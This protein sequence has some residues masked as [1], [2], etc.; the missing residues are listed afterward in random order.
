[1]ESRRQNRKQRKK[2]QNSI[3]R[4]CALM[5]GISFAFSHMPVVHVCL[6]FMILVL[7]P[8][9]GDVCAPLSQSRKSEVK[10]PK[11]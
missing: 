1:M 11:K 4:R 7:V 2:D 5:E 9:F 8:A 3:Q 10:F 6:R